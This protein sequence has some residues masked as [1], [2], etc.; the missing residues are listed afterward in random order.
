MIGWTTWDRVYWIAYLGLAW[1]A[2]SYG[3]AL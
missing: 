2:I 3:P 1:L